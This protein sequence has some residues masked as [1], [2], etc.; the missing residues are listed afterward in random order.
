LGCRRRR[1]MDDL[2]AAR[3]GTWPLLPGAARFARRRA[4]S[5]GRRV[6]PVLQAA[7][8]ARARCIALAPLAAAARMTNAPRTWHYG[9]IAEWWSHFNVDGPE[10]AYFQPFVER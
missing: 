9:L 8:G 4:R 6:P 2:A 5:S 3:L 10:I 1:R 7:A